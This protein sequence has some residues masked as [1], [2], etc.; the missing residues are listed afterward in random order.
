MKKNSMSLRSKNVL[1]NNQIIM[2][3]KIKGKL[4]WK[5]IGFRNKKKFPIKDLGY[6]WLCLLRGLLI[7]LEKKK[8]ITKKKRIEII[9]EAKR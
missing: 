1:D 2:A 9:F 5:K 6:S 4:Y 8:I 7:L 3:T